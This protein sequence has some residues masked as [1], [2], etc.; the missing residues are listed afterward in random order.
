L[1]IDVYNWLLNSLISLFFTTENTEFFSQHS[2][3]YLKSKSY[4]LEMFNLQCFND[5]DE[6]KSE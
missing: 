1:I 2:R 5:P 4:D 3:K 6:Y